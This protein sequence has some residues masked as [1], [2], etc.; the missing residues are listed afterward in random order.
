M[1]G[2]ST[3][4][5]LMVVVSFV[6][7]STATLGRLGKKNLH[8]QY[9]RKLE[10]AGLKGTALGQQWFTAAAAALQ[11]PQTITLPYR[12]T[13]YFAGDKPRAVGLRFTAP[14][15]AK[16][17]FRVE[18][19]AL[20]TFT[21]YTDLWET[22]P[23]GEPN[24]VVSLDSTGN[25]FTHEVEDADETYILRLQP[26]LLSSGEYT[27]SISVGPSLA[28]PVAG[29]KG[30]I[31]SVWGDDRDAGARRHEGIDI[32][33]PR[34]TPVVAAADGVTA[35]VGDNNLGGKVIFLRPKGKN[36]SLYYAHLDS[37]LVTSGQR[38][39]AGDTIGLVGNTGNARTT[40]PHLHFGIYAAGGAIDPFVWVSKEVKRAGSL[41]LQ[42]NKLNTYYRTT[43]DISTDSITI[44]RN[45]VLLATDASTLNLMAQLPTGKIAAVPVNST[46]TIDNQLD[47][48]ILRD[49]LPL[50]E[51]PLTTAPTKRKLL[52]G[53]PVRV[54]GYYN[55]FVFVR[56]D[57]NEEGW[58]PRSAL[59]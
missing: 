23:G 44:E 19:K 59:R 43:K 2:W 20:S 55:D 5:L 40:P 10:Q 25:E 47:R 58:M 56:T 38:V 49:S 41:P 39:S 36:V 33:A 48:Y 52:P 13:G 15:G 4:L 31:A 29:H 26:E 1:K 6:S 34:G 8:D 35:R 22:E 45:T 7:C 21:L 50:L 27:L 3:L 16:L 24:L 46:Q 54:H 51:A 37:Q 14:R 42:A 53:S 28:F 12:Q 11:S 18:S 17:H 30:N 57:D 9:G 32:F